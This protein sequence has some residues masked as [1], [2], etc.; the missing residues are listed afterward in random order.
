[1][2]ATNAAQQIVT[3]DNIGNQTLNIASLSSTANF[4]LA[5]TNTC[6]TLASGASCPLPYSFLPTTLGVLNETATLTDNN[7][8]GTNVQQTISLT[9]TGVAPVVSVNPGSYTLTANPSTVSIAAGQTGTTT[10]TVTPAGYTGSVT[11]SCLNLPA[12]TAC[13]FT[14][15]GGG[16]GTVMLSGNNQPVQVMLAVQTNVA[17]QAAAV[18]K[19]SASNSIL[20][21]LAFWWPGGIVG[22]AAFRRKKKGLMRSQQRLLQM[23]LLVLMTGA[24][25]GL[26]A[27]CGN[28][29][30]KSGTTTPAGTSSVMIT[31]TPSTGTTGL[32]QS[33]NLTLTVTQ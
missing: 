30:S 28:G 9:G 7:L 18:A 8:N 32:S 13:V 4:P 17:P 26:I 5:G 6:T 20:P 16:N 11:L 10:L 14:Q 25:A 3:L 23:G 29:T 22:L 31:S 21:V 15:T 27:G 33:L 24:M 12:N 19:Q 2:G 1:V